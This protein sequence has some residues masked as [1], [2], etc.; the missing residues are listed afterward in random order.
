MRLDPDYG[1][2]AVADS[3]DALAALVPADGELWLVEPDA[4]APRP[5]AGVRR[6]AALAQMVAPRLN[7]ARHPAEIVTL[8]EGDAAAMR[9]LAELTRPGPWHALTHRLSP[10]VGIK[11]DGRLVAMAGERMRL[12]GFAEVSGVCT[13]P[14]HRGKGYAGA[15]MRHVMRRIRARG[16][17]PFL[18]AYAANETALALYRSLGFELRATLTLT[19]LARSA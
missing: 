9:T 13:H 17:T 11:D 4:V 8:T 3:A 1:P 19:V 18:H 5:G 7:D 6:T 10:F 2:F 14:D 12:P 15:L 16:E